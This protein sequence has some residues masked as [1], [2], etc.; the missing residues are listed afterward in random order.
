MAK[1]WRWVVCGR[2]PCIADIRD[3]GYYCTKIFFGGSAV[4]SLSQ[5]VMGKAS[6]GS[7]DEAQIDESLS[8]CLNCVC[9]L[10]F[11]GWVRLWP[12]CHDRCQ[13]LFPTNCFSY[14]CSSGLYKGVQ[15]S[16]D[17]ISVVCRQRCLT[18]KPM[19]F[20]WL[21]KS[22]IYIYIYQVAAKHKTK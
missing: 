16:S 9:Y 10:H 17:F 19:L 11:M 5:G 20:Q 12:P 18:M 7:L 3:A 1:G 13:F 15:V 14:K 2:Q 21:W 22:D 6:A 4:V 8:R